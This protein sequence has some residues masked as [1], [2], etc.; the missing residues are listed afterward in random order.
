MLNLDSC[1]NVL[2]V[3]YGVS[4]KSAYEFLKKRGLEVFV[5][6]DRDEDIP[7]R[8]VDVRCQNFD[9]VIKSPSIPFMSHNCHHLIKDANEVGIPV[10][11]EFFYVKNKPNDEQ[12]KQAADFARKF[13]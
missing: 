8:V 7:D 5:Y 3:G 13:I 12:K 6:D 1:R 2:I 4:G 9:A 11:E 10:E